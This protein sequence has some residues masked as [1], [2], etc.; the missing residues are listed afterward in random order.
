MFVLY[1]KT[2]IKSQKGFYFVHNNS[3]L[4]G[5]ALSKSGVLVF[6]FQF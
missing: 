6:V 3:S 5:C 4:S 1:L 2:P